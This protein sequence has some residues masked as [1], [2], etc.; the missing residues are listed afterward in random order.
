MAFFAAMMR[1]HVDYTLSAWCDQVSA[2]DSGGGA[3]ATSRH[4]HAVSSGGVRRMP[5]FSLGSVA[6]L[7]PRREQTSFRPQSQMPPLSPRPGPAAVPGGPI[8]DAAPGAATIATAQLRGAIHNPS[9]WAPA[10]PEA[11]RPRHGR[12][13]PARLPERPHWTC[14]VPADARRPC[15]TLWPHRWD[16]PN[17]AQQVISL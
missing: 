4:L 9:E 16:D 5:C 13:R 10:T 17:R 8:A 1:W 12:P 7:A 14:S 11:S 6:R 3:R 15:W 2:V